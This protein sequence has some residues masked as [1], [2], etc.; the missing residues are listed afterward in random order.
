M[1]LATGAAFCGNCGATV[2]ASGPVSYLPALIQTNL[3]KYRKHEFASCPKCGYSGSVGR[4]G[5]KYPAG[6][7][8]WVIG[9]V[10][11]FT[12]IGAIILACQ[13]IFK[14]SVLEC[15]NCRAQFLKQV[16]LSE[17]LNPFS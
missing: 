15:P 9:I 4:I 13:F 1:A 17:S 16:P 2:M 11:T 7:W 12:L 10:F 6:W 3:G 14:K 8:A 5:E